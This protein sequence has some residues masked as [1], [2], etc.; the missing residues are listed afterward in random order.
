MADV[1]EVTTVIL[2]TEVRAGRIYR[3]RASG[4]FEYDTDY[5]RDRSAPM[6]TA[7]TS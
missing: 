3:T 1:V 4:A 5:L 2:G 7:S 6:A